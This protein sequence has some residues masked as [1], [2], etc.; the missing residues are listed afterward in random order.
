MQ[1]GSRYHIRAA[2][3]DLQP[4]ASLSRHVGENGLSSPSATSEEAPFAVR[5]TT[6]DDAP[7]VFRASLPV[8][9]PNSLI[10]CGDSNRPRVSQGVLWSSAELFVPTSPARAGCVIGSPG[11]HSG[12]RNVAIDRI[13]Y[14]TI[15]NCEFRPWRLSL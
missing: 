12:D 5:A 3:R 14:G 10:R 2:V 13:S 9:S 4:G 11:D 1:L 8:K 7:F 15:Q 6:C